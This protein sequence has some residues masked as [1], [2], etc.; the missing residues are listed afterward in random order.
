A[1]VAGATCLASLLADHRV[2]HDV[3]MT[4]EISLRGKVLS[5]GGIK[6]K[7]LAAHRAT[8]KTV[9]LP[10]GNRKDLLQIPEKVRK[11]L[12]IV[13]AERV[14]DVWREALTPILLPKRGEAARR[15]DAREY[16]IDQA[17]TQPQGS[18]HLHARGAQP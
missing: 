17:G 4:G 7:V 14:Q 13:F 3:A 8:I 2:R 11:E 12:R 18:V 5:V 6:E 15:F 9:V 16:L 10:E 1:G